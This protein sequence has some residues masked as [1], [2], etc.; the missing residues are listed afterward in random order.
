MWEVLTWSIEETDLF[1]GVARLLFSLEYLE[2]SNL[3]R[4]SS[5][6]CQVYAS[7]QSRYDG[8]NAP[9]YL[10]ISHSKISKKNH[11]CEIPPIQM[12]KFIIQFYIIII[13]KSFIYNISNWVESPPHTS[14]AYAHVGFNIYYIVSLKI[15]PSWGLRSLV[16][17]FHVSAVKMKPKIAK[18]LRS[19]G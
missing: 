18:L 4:H 1:G 11:L 6:G 7:G 19:E 14:M 17:G 2:R 13:Y 9:L 3:G 8:F 12:G 5:I 10:K 16:W 15:L